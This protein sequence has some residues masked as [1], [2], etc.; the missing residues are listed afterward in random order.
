MQSAITLIKGDKMGSETDYRDALPV[1]MYPI[2]RPVLGADGYMLQIEGLTQYASA[3]GVDRGGL[4]N[5]RHQEHYRV[6]GSFLVKVSEGGIVTTLGVVSGNSQA[7][8][9]YSFNTQGV[10]AGGNFYLYSP[11]AGFSQ[12]TDPDLGSP[13]DCVWVDGYYFFTDGEYIYH[14]DINNESAIDPLK[15]A[16]AEFMPDKSLGVGKTQD[17]KVIVFGR[18][19]TEYFINAANDNFAF[20]RVPTRAI[21][22]GIVGTHAKCELNDRWYLLGGRKEDSPSVFVMGVGE[23]QKVAS[24]EVDKIIATYTETDMQSAVLESR[25]IAGNAYV[26]VHLPSHCLCYS[27]TV[28]QKAGV[29]YAW[30]I[31]CTG[32]DGQQWRA[33]NGIYEP[34]KGVWVYGDKIDGRIGVLDKDVATQYGAISEW[35]IYT[36]LMKLETQSVDELAI[37]SIPGHTGNPDAT[38]FLSMTYDGVTYGSEWTTMYG[39]PND[40]SKRFI[41]YRLGY[42]RDMFGFKLRGASRSRMAFGRATLEHG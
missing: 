28:A 27:E 30:T 1:N 42:I 20:S 4:W 5:E 15:F 25:V 7:A 17:N 10:V 31:L 35:L 9:P 32:V 14:S 23:V 40:Y 18:Y 38:A 16:T 37:E 11:T 21:K 19:S 24:R 41:L 6:S 36:P 26:I 33:K 2:L 22:A 29:D 3:D 8:L 34:R 12:V 39:L 13:I